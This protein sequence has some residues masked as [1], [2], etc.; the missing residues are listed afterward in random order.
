V[1]STPRRFADLDCWRSAKVDIDGEVCVGGLLTSIV[2]GVQKTDA[3][4][5]TFH[6]GLLTSIVG[7]VQKVGN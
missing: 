1:D 4:P 3:L 5:P 6:P 2:G 7:G